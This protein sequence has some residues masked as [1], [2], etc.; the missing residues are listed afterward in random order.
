M[1]HPISLRKFGY[2]I[3]VPVSKDTGTNYRGTTLVPDNA[4]T[5]LY[6]TLNMLNAHT[7]SGLLRLHPDNSGGKIRFRYLSDR[8]QRLTVILFREMV[9][10]Y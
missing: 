10:N 4:N 6:Q 1:R 2:K 9:P 8:S 7:R 5:A 3:K